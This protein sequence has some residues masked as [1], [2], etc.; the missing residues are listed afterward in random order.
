MKLKKLLRF[1]LRNY[2]VLVFFACILFVGMV[3]VYKLFL[4]KPTYVYT[5]V[6]MGQGLWWAS[7]QRPAVWFIETLKKRGEE[8]NLTGSPIAE[9]LNVRYYP[10]YGSSQYDVYLTLRLKV[11]GNP[12]TGKYNF[13]R[14]TIGVGSPIDLEFPSVQISGTI[15]DL[16]EKPFEERFVTKTVTLTKKGAFPWEFNAINVG[17]KYFDGERVVFEIIDKKSTDVAQIAGDSYGN[18]I[19]S[20]LEPKKYIMVKAKI[21]AQEK[22][23]Q[24]IFGEEQIISLGKTI[25][26]STF[27][28]TFNDYA[29]GAIE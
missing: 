12:K 23:N 26:I 14:S 4:I 11:S 9:M 3:S 2:F 1:L 5:K 10:W 15:I 25:N 24:L 21:K 19:G 13:K 20:D 22:N 28:F 7:T 18:Y 29:I 17:D 8:K 16:N 6:K 27:G